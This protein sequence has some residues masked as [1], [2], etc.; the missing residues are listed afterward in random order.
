MIR[1]L[2]FP[3]MRGFMG[4]RE[5]YST[6][7]P[8]TLIPKFFTFNDY[9]GI[10]PEQREQR[11]LNQSR[12]PGIAEYMIENEDGWLFS[13]ITASYKVSEG[14]IRF[15][16]FSENDPEIGSLEVDP[17]VV[18]FIINDGQHRAAGIKEALP[19]SGSLKDEAISV[20][21]FPYERLD[22]VQ[23]MF[24]DLNKNVVK[25]SK[26]L[27]ILYDHR[28][29]LAE[30]VRAAVEQV[31]VFEGLVD[32]DAQSLSVR[33]NFLFTLTAIYDASEELR[34]Y[35]KGEEII[36]PETVTELVDFWGT[37]SEQIP[38]WGKVRDGAISSEDMRRHKIS[39]HSVV[40]RAIGGIGSELKR[41]SPKGDSGWKAKIAGLRHIDWR[42]S[43]R[44]WESV[45][46]VA[47][48]VISN[49]QAR[50]AT[51]AFLKQKL[52]LTLNDVEAVALGI[53]AAPKTLNKSEK[54][55]GKSIAQLVKL[56]AEPEEAREWLKESVDL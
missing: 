18:S 30:A 17:S 31:H 24:T 33:S 52:G 50:V 5:Y 40:L 16:P 3:A 15:V 19:K 44:D 37:V 47:N 12:V 51:K 8:L 48:S 14:L 7:M 13:S 41:D 27:N 45:C 34:N 43:N 28:D 11:K 4:Q 42:K 35:R 25:P 56:G 23:Q 20:L 49:R 22:R 9:T 55:A 32:K 38:D 10:S 54:I 39:A 21:L 6:L 2:R 29:P 46:I 53:H 1:S 36:I 26:S